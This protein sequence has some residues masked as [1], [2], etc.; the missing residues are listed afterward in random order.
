MRQH[1]AA[2]PPTRPDL[3][4]EQEEPA[5]GRYPAAWRR[6]VRREAVSG[7]ENPWKEEVVDNGSQ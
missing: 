7:S 5:A 2:R 6:P 1:V 4:K 3:K